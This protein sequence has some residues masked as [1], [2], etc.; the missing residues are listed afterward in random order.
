[1]RRLV[2]AMA[3]GLCLAATTTVAWADP[4]AEVTLAHAGRQSPS[5][6][7][8]P[9][10][11]W[12]TVTSP[13]HG[14]P[15]LPTSPDVGKDQL[16]VQ[17]SN[18]VPAVGALGAAPTSSQAV[19]AIRWRIPAG[20]TPTAVTLTIAGQAPPAVSI[21]ACRITADFKP[22]SGGP[23]SQ[24]PAHTCA[25]PVD[26][27][28]KGSTVTFA[29][30]GRLAQGHALS[31]LL[32]P[33]P[34]D[35]EVI[36]QPGPSAL[37]LAKAKP[38]AKQKKPT[39]P[40][41]NPGAKPSPAHPGT[42]AGAPPGGPAVGGGGGGGGGF[43]APAPPGNA[44]VAPPKGQS[45]QVAGTGSGAAPP[46]TGNAAPAAA[47]LPAAGW[48]RLVAGLIVAAE[49]AVFAL[50]QLRRPRVVPEGEPVTGRGVGRFVRERSGGPVTL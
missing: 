50:L 16:L 40:P 3:A 32:V 17:G 11:A 5:N 4:P 45:P 15:G 20:R 13:G 27:T 36:A 26:A 9:T 39:P 18:A 41:T 31:I 25:H 35:R 21:Q 28:L 46:A 22:V 6:P 19:S 24:V 7:A 8:K 34:L 10:T 29:G 14:L 33:G 1:M 2:G 37:T 43:A 23:Y 48:R 42:G 38:R 47:L 44:A 30:V 49:V 12:W